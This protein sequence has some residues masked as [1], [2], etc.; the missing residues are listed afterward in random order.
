MHKAYAACHTDRMLLRPAEPD[1]AIDVA[2]VHVRAWQAGYRGLLAQEYL[3]SLRAEDRARRYDFANGDPSQP[4][5]R[6]AVVDGLVR[7]FVTTMPAR[8]VVAPMSGELCALYVDPDWW[9]RGLGKALAV[10]ARVRLREQGFRDAVLWLLAGN[11][12]GER[13]YRGDGWVADG[14]V[15]KDVVWGVAVDE[16]RYRRALD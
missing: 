9:G 8:D 14:T 1:D 3:D 5:T 16:V 13:F 4:A 15:R 11:R 10:A 7:G 6:V 12:R 2:R